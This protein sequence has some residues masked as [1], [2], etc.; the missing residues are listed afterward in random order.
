MNGID[1]FIQQTELAHGFREK[2]LKG[3]SDEQGLWQP[4]PGIPP[5][6][7]HT[8]HVALVETGLFLGMGKGELSELAGRWYPLYRMGAPLP[9][10]L[11]ILPKLSELAPAV[12]EW[13]AETLDFVKTLK[14][15][16]LSET[17]PHRKEGQVPDFI[18]TYGDCLV[19]LGVHA[20]HHNGEISLLRRQLGMDGLV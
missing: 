14:P 15:A 20:G 12:K 11:N 9:V 4:Q 7:W 17:L 10:D 18:Q 19:V 1:L 3:I 6:A 8:G 5:I 16:D 13:R 2:L